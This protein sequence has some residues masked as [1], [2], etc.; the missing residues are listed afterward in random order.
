M[1]MVLNHDQ[2]LNYPW[3]VSAY[4]QLT[5]PLVQNRAHHAL[6][7]K[8][9]PGS[10]EELL[11]KQLSMRHLCLDPQHNYPCYHCHSCQLFL[12]NNH[13]DYYL[14]APEKNKT[15]IGVDQ[16]R[17][18]LTN[19]YEHSQQGGNK[20]IWL[21]N[22]STMT[23]AAA[24]A[25]LKTLE[26]PPQNTY[27][28]LSDQHNGQ[29]LPTIYSRCQYHYLT[30]PELEESIDWLKKQMITSAYHT[31]ELATALLLNQKAPLAALA[32]LDENQWQQRSQF[33]GD[34][35]VH[36]TEQDFWSLRNSIINQ[37]NLL[38]RLHWVCSLFS[39]ALK[40]RQKSGHYITN[41]DHVPLIRLIATF[42]IEKI[43]QLY[44]SWHETLKL[45][46]TSNGLNQELIIS[47]LL[48]NSEIILNS[49]ES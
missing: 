2:L 29:L 40:A 16:I 21:N 32:L 20:L 18:I 48:A 17:Q 11:I 5:Q 31:N 47:N 7:L 6:L 13:P 36:L 43:I 10:G 12:A 28:I 38:T 46:L 45:L 41:R 35:Q 34:L 4:Q 42:G 26:E 37:D 30:V 44:T 49:P 14:V 39:D 19:V 8:Y 24:N 9:I 1:A 33:Y 15:S 25:L 23:E 22:A 27:F 3:L